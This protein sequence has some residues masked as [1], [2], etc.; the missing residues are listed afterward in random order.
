MSIIQQTL[1]S[2]I[3]LPGSF[4]LRRLGDRIIGCRYTNASPICT[5]GEPAWHAAGSRKGKDLRA[6]S[7]LS[8]LRTSADAAGKLAV[9]RS[10]AY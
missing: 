3:H 9:T 8:R 6:V 2:R 5:F 4:C 7:I 1:P 10:G